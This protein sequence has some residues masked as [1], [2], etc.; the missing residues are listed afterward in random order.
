MC[1]RPTV[2][3]DVGG[4]A[5]VVGPGGLAGIVVPPRDP[6]ALATAL[7]EL[8]QNKDLR[9]RMGLH[10]R[11]HAMQNFSLTR[12]YDAVRD[13]YKVRSADTPSTSTGLSKQSVAIPPEE[14]AS[15]QLQEVSPQPAS[16][17][18]TRAARHHAQTSSN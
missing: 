5:E 6:G 12:F 13:L 3:T 16:L 17:P 18:S 11:E 1:G 4:V 9:D 8:L 2:S 7:I 15:S 14:A 10:A